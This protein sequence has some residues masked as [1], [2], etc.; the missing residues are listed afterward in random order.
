MKCMLLD[1]KETDTL[2][3]KLTLS[4]SFCVPPE[5]GS[6]LKGSFLNFLLE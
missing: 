5:K 3:G 6:T 2:S 1:L 4:K